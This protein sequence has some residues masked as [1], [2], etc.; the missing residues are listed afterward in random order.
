MTF[1]AQL[2]PTG[3]L[4]ATSCSPQM[5]DGQE[6]GIAW[7]Q[8]PSA[9]WIE[10]KETGRGKREKKNVPIRAGFLVGCLFRVRPFSK[11]VFD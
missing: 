10:R 5:K 11:R 1:S 4:S 3:C 2:R 7:K 6:R 8:A 9:N